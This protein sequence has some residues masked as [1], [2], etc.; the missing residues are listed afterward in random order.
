MT[1]T[2]PVDWGAFPGELLEDVMAVLLLQERRRAQHRRPSQGDGGVDVYDPTDDEG[3]D[4]Y[5]VKGFSSALTRGQKRKIKRSLEEVRSAPRLLLPVRRWFLVLPLDP[6]EGDDEWFEELTQDATFECQWLGR[7]FWNSEAAKHPHVVDYYLRGG[8]DRLLRRVTSLTSLLQQPDESLQ[9]ADLAPTLV[10]LLAEVN[11]DDPHYVYEFHL[12]Q[13]PLEPP[14]RPGVVLARTE[15]VEGQ[16][17]VT[18]VVRAKYP[19]AL[20][21]RPIRGS[22]NVVLRDPGRGIDL[23]EDW[24]AFDEFG[25][26]LVLPVEA[27]EDFSVDAPGGLGTEG[28]TVQTALSRPSAVQVFDEVVLR[29][30]S[31]DG[32]ELT[33]VTL[34]IDQPP[35]VGSKGLRF[36]ARGIAFDFDAELE[37]NTASRTV[38]TTFHLRTHDVS[39]QPAGAALAHLRWLRFLQAPNKLEMTVRTHGADAGGGAVD[40]AM[41]DVDSVKRISEIGLRVAEMLSDLEALLGLTTVMPRAV[42][43]SDLQSLTWAWMLARG[44]TV[45]GTWTEATLTLDDPAQLVAAVN[46]GDDLRFDA[47]ESFCFAGTEY[48]LGL[49]SRIL[50]GA[51]IGQ[52]RSVELGAE[53]V[54]QSADGRAFERLLGPA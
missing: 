15:G 36:E 34:R 39:G 32:A 16:G 17:F 25:H 22:F 51:E 21:D 28:G 54:L 47:F 5:Q 7:T 31:P 10:K 1:T 27:V 48:S 23:V 12:T 29:I 50:Q 40:I 33:T 8:K 37:M 45:D 35:T 6:H 24:R 14:S 44:D 41:L 20:L 2:G 43:Q 46:R 38:T 42:D 4:V 52:I 18:V 11:R 30:L 49:V 19:Q 9:P 26:A 53:V 13:E 3:Y